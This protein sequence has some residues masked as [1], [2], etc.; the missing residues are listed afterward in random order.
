MARK[1]IDIGVQG[2]D[3]TGD[4]IRESFRKTNENF[5]ELYSVFG[6]GGQISFINLTDTPATYTDS[7]DKFL[8]VNSTSTGVTFKTLV[9]AGGITVNSSGSNA[10]ITLTS[11]NVSLDTG[12]KLS[13]HLNAQNQLI[14]G[15]RDPDVLT[16]SQFNTFYG[17][18]YTVDNFAITKGYADTR[19]VNVTG[20]TMTGH[21]SVPANA[22]ATQVPQAQAVVHKAGDT[23][24]GFLTLHADPT[25]SL[26][27][28]TKQY[29]DALVEGVVWKEAVK[30]KS[31]SNVPLTGLVSNITLLNID[32][33]GA[34]DDG[35]QL[36]LTG[37]TEDSE[38]GIYVYNVDGITYTLTRPAQADTASEL[39][40]AAVFVLEGTVYNKTG[41][42]Q[43]NH[44]LTTFSSQDWVQFTGVGTYTAGTGLT[45][46]GSQFS[47][48]DTSTVVNLSSNNSDNTFIQDIAFGFDT[49]GH[50]TSA[51][52]STGTASFTPPNTFQTVGINGTD[53]GYTWGNAG[54]NTNQTADSST[55]TLTLVKGNGI[56]LF[57]NTIA[58]NDAIKIEHADTSS[59]VNLTASSRTY[60]TG[61]TFDTF[62]HVTA[63][64]T[65]S[66]TVVDTNTTYS[67]SAE[68]ATGGANLR[69]SAGGSGSGTD[70]VKIAG[71]T[72]VSVTRT[73]ANTITISSSF[74]DT[75]YS[76]ATSTV[77]GLV[78]LGS[79]AQQS[80]AATAVSATASRTYAIQA[81]SNGQ[82]VVN[83]PWVDT[84]TNTVTSVGISGQQATGTIT[85][86]GSGATSVTQTGSTITISSTDTNTTYSAASS[87]V[88]GLVELFSDTVQT[89]A[90]TAVSATA[91]RT[92]G[93]QVNSAGQMVVNVP[94]VDTNTT[95]SAGT[96]VSINGSNQISI[97]QA[98]ATTSAVTFATLNLAV[99]TSAP[100]SPSNGMLA[101]ANGTTWDPVT[102][103]KQSLV[104]Y[105]SGAWVLVAAG[106]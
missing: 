69:L 60:V 26:H 74:T 10:I 19:Y 37:Q 28:T 23:M 38:N 57:A 68:T 54:V 76:A 11:M 56:D 46:T 97:G 16:V 4:S 9:G 41:W 104:V 53:S 42:V 103:G 77:F 59:A 84:D 102:N 48:A 61:L 78:K 6:Q 73:D 33:Y 18:N 32:G 94:W 98:V 17:T 39:I 83:V 36:L 63:Y 25:S 7:A 92:Y 14:G 96:G 89:V 47:H 99:S 101:V 24:T 58:G 30:L 105:L 52:V 62:G 31:D 29:V 82:L 50:V 45:L 93:I 44:Y 55:D 2:N 3:G 71:G 95:Y 20:D 12:P 91:S 49:F 88:A 64:T 8:L 40:G 86:A 66:E 21:L 79:D 87:S 1:E 81:N 22:T 70:D 75:T 106:A 51:T 90:A 35:Y 27:A 100:S 85:L 5:Q 72:N 67:I 15:L 34:L 80:V 65:G 43:T 13:Y